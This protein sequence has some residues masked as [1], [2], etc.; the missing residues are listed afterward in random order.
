MT[1]Q[2]HDDG[3]S[4]FNWRKAF[5][6]A[7]TTYNPYYRAAKFAIDNRKKFGNIA[8][9]AATT[10]NPYY[11]AA[12]FAYKRRP[13][14]LRDEY[15]LSDYSGVYEGILSEIVNTPTYQQFLYEEGLSGLEDSGELAGRFGTW[16]KTKALPGIK[17]AQGALS[18]FIGLLPGGGV[19]NAAFDIINRPKGGGMPAES[20]PVLSPMLPPAPMFPQQTTQMPEPAQFGP[21]AGGYQ[22]PQM[23]PASSGF[24]LP[25]GLTPLS[26]GAIA[27]GGLLAYKV[28]KK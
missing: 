6:S 14:F 27:I 21:Y 12:K 5:K 19:V 10:Y 9:E 22:I 8:K 7:A 11:R 25:F 2:L 17:K 28:L 4:G 16:V 18:P 26:L 15:M 1:L 24:Q 23:A 13:R 20:T 3:L